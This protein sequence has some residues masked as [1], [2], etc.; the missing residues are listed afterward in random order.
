MQ[1]EAEPDKSV[2]RELPRFVEIFLQ[3]LIVVSII[4]LC[5]E[6]MPELSSFQPWFDTEET[7]IVAIFT[8][9][10]FVRWALSANKRRYPFTFMAIVD[11]LAVL[12]FYMNWHADLR[13]LRAV[14]LMRISR[15]LKLGRYN[16]SL[17][18][19]GEAVYLVRSELVVLATIA[20]I[21]LL[22]SSMGLYYAE[23]DAQ[24]EAFRSIPESLWWAV[25]TLTTVGYGDVCPKTG[26]GRLIASA[27]MISGIGLIA[28]PTGLISSSFTELLRRRRDSL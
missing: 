15:I 3:L 14:R 11:L 8:V 9:E 18:L 28:I 20:G 22:I 12:P 23:R 7:V 2:S 24:P 16:Q 25:V 27:V 5:L 17:K 10:Y 26:I 19:L 21:V 4:S 1:A 13:S 6:T